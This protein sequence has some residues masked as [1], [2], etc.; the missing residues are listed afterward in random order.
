MESLRDTERRLYPYR[1]TP[2]STPAQ[3]EADANSQNAVNPLTAHQNKLF[4]PPA[5]SDEDITSH[6]PWNLPPGVSQGDYWGAEG[7][8]VGGVV[9]QAAADTG[10]IFGDDMTFGT[11][12]FVAPEGYRKSVDEARERAGG[13]KYGID[14]MA[15]LANKPFQAARLGLGATKAA[16]AGVK[17]IAP[18]ASK[19]AVKAIARRVGNFI[20][21][22]AYTGAQSVGHGDDATTVGANTVLGGGLGL[23]GDEAFSAAKDAGAWLRSKWGGFQGK[24]FTGGTPEGTPQEIVAGAPPGAPPRTPEGYMDANQLNLWRSQAAHDMPPSQDNVFSYAKGVYGPDPAQWPEALRDIHSAAGSEGGPS[25]AARIIGHSATQ[26]GAATANYLGLGFSPEVAAI[27]HPALASATEM[28]LPYFGYG[29][30][31]VKSAIANAYPALTG[32]RNAP[33]TP[34]WRY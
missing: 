33:N 26:A 29:A 5:P 34:D 22:G 28:T 24:P 17:A 2:E 1:P 20:E 4:P 15:F 12:G 6:N 7:R 25:T 16:A 31:P 11:P 27:A 19:D 23:V 3:P 32:W 14:A 8:K 30:A 9:G 13:G 18:Q 21:G 10:L